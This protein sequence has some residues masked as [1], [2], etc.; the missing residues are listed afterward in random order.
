MTFE[1]AFFLYSSYL[2]DKLNT[3]ASRHEWISK[4][5]SSEQPDGSWKLVGSSTDTVV[6]HISEDP[7]FCDFNPLKE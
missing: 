2:Q 1:R 3:H 6:A 7:F 5:L 4:E